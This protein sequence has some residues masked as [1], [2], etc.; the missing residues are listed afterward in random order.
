MSSLNLFVEWFKEYY[1]HEFPEYSTEFKNFWIEK[2]I[3]NNGD[4]I[5]KDFVKK[6]DFCDRCGKCCID[7]FS[8]CEYFD[9][10]TKLCLVH[11]NQPWSVCGDYPYGAADLIGPLTLNC[12]YMIR[13]FIKYLDSFFASYEEEDEDA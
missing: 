8:N 6:N 7:Q 2:I 5:S 1:Y 12:K 10:E 3:M 9:K 11:D 4:Y 13:I